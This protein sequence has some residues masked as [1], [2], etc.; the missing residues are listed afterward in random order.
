[1]RESKALELYRR[2]APAALG[3]P[4]AEVHIVDDWEFV[5]TFECQNGLVE[6]PIELWRTHRAVWMIEGMHRLK[7]SIYGK[8]IFIKLN[9]EG[10]EFF[11]VD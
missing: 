7:S 10:R 1:M 8:H 3:W 9:E 4:L 2:L 11:G 6:M 5:W